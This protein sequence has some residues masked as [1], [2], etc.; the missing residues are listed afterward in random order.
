MYMLATYVV[1]WKGAPAMLLA[2]LVICT[3]CVNNLQ[4]LQSV[5]GAEGVPNGLTALGYHRM[6][7]RA[8]EQDPG[9]ATA[10][11]GGLT[12]REQGKNAE[13]FHRLIGGL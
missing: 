5:F 11:T 7:K 4:A 2:T 10:P 8:L 1:H 3:V 13:H 9:L 12:G 6:W